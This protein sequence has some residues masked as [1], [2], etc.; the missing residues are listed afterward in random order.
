MPA[1]KISLPYM[2]T[3]VGAGWA[4]VPVPGEWAGCC[5]AV[6]AR[7]GVGRASPS[8]AVGPAHLGLTDPPRWGCLHLPYIRGQ[9]PSPGLIVWLVLL[10][11]GSSLWVRWGCCSWGLSLGWWGLLCLFLHGVFRRCLLGQLGAGGQEQPLGFPGQG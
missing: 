1:D 2:K 11:L 8:Q 5:G 3:G 4:V 10:R 6:L 9:K 7:Q